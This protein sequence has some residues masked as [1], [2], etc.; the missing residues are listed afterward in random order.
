VSSWRNEVE[1]G[2]CDVDEVVDDNLLMRKEEGDVE[3]RDVT[4]SRNRPVISRNLE[5]SYGCRPN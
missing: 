4:K 3:S 2:G 1:I 5:M